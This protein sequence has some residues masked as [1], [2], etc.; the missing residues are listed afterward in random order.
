MSWLYQLI[1]PVLFKV[2]AEQAHGLAV[3]VLKL[4]LMPK[5]K[6]INDP[7]LKQ[8]VLGMDFYHP[9]G[10]AAGFDKNADVYDAMLSQGFAFTEIGSVTPKAQPGNDKPRLFRLA[11]DQ[12]VINRMGFNNAGMDVVAGNLAPRLHNREGIVGVN[13]GK[14]KTTENAVDDYVLGINRLAN[15]AD[16]MVIN[17]SSPNT[18]GLRDLQG[19]D[20]LLKLLAAVKSALTNVPA[21]KK[22]PLLL[23]VAP[24]LTDQDK[25]DIADVAMECAIDGLIV[26]NTTVTRP[27][28]MMDEQSHETG[29][30]SGRPLMTLSTD[31]LKDFYKRTNGKLLLIGVGGVSSAEDAYQKIRS[32]A[33]LVQLY[34]AM[35]YQGPSIAGDIARGLSDL[36]AADGFENVADAVG[37]DV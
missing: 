31:V 15:F 10:L 16:Y 36:L 13:L 19:R 27:K 20:Q 37:V 32:G 25:Q 34:S 12:A 11:R 5:H 14:N 9:I 7:R 21:G 1:K 8:S 22:I 24:D 33:T 29:G 30:L 26:S 6:L 4:G 28:G 17:V 35:V 2:D 3:A 18:P 23:K